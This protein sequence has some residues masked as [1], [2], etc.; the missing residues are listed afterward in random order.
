MLIG[1]AGALVYVVVQLIAD[2]ELTV[3]K[4]LMEGKYIKGPGMVLLFLLSGGLVAGLS[5]AS[6]GRFEP[7]NIWTSFLIGFG[8]QGVIAGVGGSAAM[9]AKD[10]EDKAVVADTGSTVT[11]LVG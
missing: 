6:V 9:R 5:Q 8:W 11:Q 2:K 3:L 10:A 4:N 1:F 7:G